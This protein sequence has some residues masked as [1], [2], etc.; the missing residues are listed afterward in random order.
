MLS[1]SAVPPCLCV[2]RVIPLGAS[3]EG[4]VDATHQVSHGPLVL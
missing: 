2:S 4:T 3:E 1:H